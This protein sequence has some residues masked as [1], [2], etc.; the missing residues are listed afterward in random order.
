MKEEV[1]EYYADLRQE[2]ATK[3]R[4]LVPKYD[5]MVELIIDL[6]RL[7][8]PGTVLDIGAGTGNVLA[9]VLQTFP[10]SRVTALEPCDEMFAEA[11]R[12]LSAFS[13]R[14]TFVKEDI[15]EFVPGHRY[16]AIISNLVL[17]NLGR[18]EKQRLLT[19]LVGW[20]EPGGR[21]IWSDLIRHS[22]D[23][24]QTHFIEYRKRF[25]AE[26]GCPGDVVETDSRKEAELDHPLTV[27]ETLDMA[28]RA[29]FER[30]S[31]AWVHDMFAMLLLQP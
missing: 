22:D 31:V 15:L 10:R 8:E 17:H 20:L 1:R 27:E 6:L 24:L 16:D 11:A 23:R 28:H 29:G 3:I 14:A 21:F 25:A 18:G 5:E 19:D 4:Q 12:V 9:A 26:A 30:A 2:Y 7:D 13:D